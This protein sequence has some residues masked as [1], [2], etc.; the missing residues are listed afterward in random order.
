MNEVLQRGN[1]K[2]YKQKYNIGHRDSPPPDVERE[3]MLHRELR[4][5]LLK[6]NYEKRELQEKEEIKK[7]EVLAH[8][9]MYNFQHLKGYR[10]RTDQIERMKQSIELASIKAQ[11]E[12][13]H[14][15]PDS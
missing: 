7:G 14:A 15:S 13:T 12:A 8:Q 10:D 6:E 3:D 2:Y 9:D 4:F 11:Q 1:L 5:E